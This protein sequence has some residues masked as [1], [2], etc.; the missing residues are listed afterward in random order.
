MINAEVEVAGP[1]AEPIETP[2]GTFEVVEIRRISFPSPGEGK[3]EPG[4]EIVYFYS[5]ATKSVVKLIAKISKHVT[6]W[7]IPDHI[8]MELIKYGRKSS[9]SGRSVVK[10]P[11]VE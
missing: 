1:L 10:A 11:V 9:P 7:S 2:A 3:H 6:D 5:P 8:E 4:I